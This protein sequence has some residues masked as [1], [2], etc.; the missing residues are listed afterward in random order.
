MTEALN[1][2]PIS[3]K[4]YAQIR[5]HE[6]LGIKAPLL[7]AITLGQNW[8][9]THICPIE[10]VSADI[11]ENTASVPS[12][13]RII[14]AETEA[15]PKECDV[16]LE[17]ELPQLPQ[18][19]QNLALISPLVRESDFIDVQPVAKENVAPTGQ[20]RVKIASSDRLTYSPIPVK[21]HQQKKQ[22]NLTASDTTPAAWSSISDL[23]TN[24]DRTDIDNID[25]V[26]NTNS[27]VLSQSSNS[28]VI[29]PQQRSPTFTQQTTYS[30]QSSKKPDSRN[31]ELLA[32]EVYA[33]IQQK[34]MLEREFH[35]QSSS[36][37]LPW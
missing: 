2:D 8:Q 13:E 17:S 5:P 26:M 7:P 27:H 15:Q 20:Q 31:L 37:K 33:F 6:P 28:T 19:L 22:P 14:A 35:T 30:R 4:C 12:S 11:T 9:L 36:G 29:S 21:H 16:E 23:L 3:S 34:L 1:D 24:V 32:Q 25:H 18:V 10:L